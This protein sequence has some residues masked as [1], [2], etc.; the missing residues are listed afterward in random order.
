M[1]T[2]GRLEIE[3]SIFEKVRIISLQSKEK[4][5]PY[6]GSKISLLSLKSSPS[7]RVSIDKTQSKFIDI[8][9]QESAASDKFAFRKSK[10][11]VG[12]IVT[13]TTSNFVDKIVANENMAKVLSIP[14]ENYYLFYNVGKSLCWTDYDWTLKSPLSVIHLKEAYISCHDVNLMTRDS[15]NAVVGFN[16]GDILCFWPLSG[17]YTRLNRYG[18]ISKSAVTTIKWIPVYFINEGSE[19]L[20]MA[21]FKDG[22]LMI[23]DKDLDDQSYTIPI[24]PDFYSTNA[25]AGSKNNPRA[26]WK[27]SPSSIT[28]L[29]FSPD[30]QHVAVTAMDGTLT[31]LDHRDGLRLDVYS[32]FFGGFLCVSWSPDGKFIVAGGQDDLISLFS[33]RGRLIALFQGHKSWVLIFN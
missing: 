17:K 26:Y 4:I 21:G 15:M 25:P 29:E 27:L 19:N 30:L 20:F 18:T 14:G 31:I 9:T 8:P 3:G 32:S 12:S 6:L 1:Q 7:Q 2:I 13:K 16:T 24:S 11:S 28:A 33:F 23:F 5:L 10:K 22:S